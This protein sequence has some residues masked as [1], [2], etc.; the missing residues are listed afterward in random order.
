M[1]E[2]IE[3]YLAIEK[4]SGVI[5]FHP[6]TYY[7]DKVEKV[8]KDI[9]YLI[10]KAKELRLNRCKLIIGKGNAW[11]SDNPGSLMGYVLKMTEGKK[12]RT[13]IRNKKL[14]DD[15]ASLFLEFNWPYECNTAQYEQNLRQEADMRRQKLDRAKEKSNRLRL[16]DAENGF[17]HKNSKKYHRKI[18]S[19]MADYYSHIKITADP[20]TY[21]IFYLDFPE[22]IPDSLRK[23]FERLLWQ[24]WFSIFFDKSSLIEQKEMLKE[25]TGSILQF[26]EFFPLIDDIT[27]K[28]ELNTLLRM[29][30]PKLPPNVLRL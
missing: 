24:I 15:L 1:K 14:S 11:R 4:G 12:I 8:L 6:S 26:A 23:K 19:I 28:E 17:F 2:P 13:F 3:N 18:R 22:A 21:L 16:N 7:T 29:F 10:M 30:L 27:E 9:R 25:L 20:A 5:D